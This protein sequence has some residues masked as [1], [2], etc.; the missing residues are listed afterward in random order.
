[1]SSRL[2]DGFAAPWTSDSPR[3]VV[4]STT[5]ASRFGRGAR[6]MQV[7]AAVGPAPAPSAA[8]QQTP[9][10]DLRDDAELRLWLRSTLAGDGRPGRPVYLTLEADTDPASGAPWRRPLPV[11]RARTWELHRLWLGDMP[12]PIR[13]AV[14]VLRLRGLDPTAA[15]TAALSDLLAV[16]PRAIADTEQALLARLHDRYRVPAAPG[17]GTT[18]LPAG[19]AG[20]GVAAPAPPAIAITAWRVV[21]AARPEGPEAVDNRTPTGAAI[22]AASSVVGL[23]YRIDVI[24]ADRGDTAHVLDAMVI[25]LLRPLVVAGAPIA[26]EPFA[27][28]PEPSGRTPL[29]VR[30]SVPVETGGREFHGLARP[31]LAVGHIDDRPGAE[32]LPA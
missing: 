20:P 31:L 26:V 19:F 10:L 3:W 32:A 28:P 21:P 6:G 5:G 8:A 11:G 12:T 1:M 18:T 23:E 7:V 14:A 13:S 29:F 27:G 30:L 16:T 17:P 22:R 9:A 4:T 15:F 25:D 24:A 2:I